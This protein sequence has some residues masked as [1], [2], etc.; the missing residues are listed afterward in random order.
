MLLTRGWGG[1]VTALRKVAEVVSSTASL[2][3]RWR[4]ADMRAAGH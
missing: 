3:P 4:D 1:S 2:C